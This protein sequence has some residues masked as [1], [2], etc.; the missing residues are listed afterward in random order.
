LCL[1]GTAVISSSRARGSTAISFLDG[2]SSNLSPSKEEGAPVK[3]CA[4][5]GVGSDA[6]KV[7][8]E[9]RRT[10]N[11]VRVDLFGKA[12]KFK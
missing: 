2:G 5:P 8:K 7:I 3:S 12:E 11:S 4:E 6:S 10:S 1:G 9:S